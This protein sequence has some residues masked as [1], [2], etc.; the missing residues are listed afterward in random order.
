MPDAHQPPMQQF[1]LVRA[2][3]ILGVM[4][5][6]QKD[7]NEQRKDIHTDTRLSAPVERELGENSSSD[8]LSRCVEC[9]FWAIFL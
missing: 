4:L 1:F 7:H 2:S 5:P 8:P 9:P 6:P 3:A